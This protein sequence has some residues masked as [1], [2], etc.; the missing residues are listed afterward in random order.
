MKSDKGDNRIKALV[1]APIVIGLILIVIGIVSKINGVL[2]AGIAVLFGGSG[3]AAFITV[4][5]AM[6]WLKR[7]NSEDTDADGIESGK[8]SART[9]KKELTDSER[10]YR[11][12]IEDELT[13]ESESLLEIDYE[14]TEADIDELVD[15]EMEIETE[16]IRSDETDEDFETYVS[17]R[18]LLYEEMRQKIMKNPPLDDELFDEPEA[19]TP[20]DEPDGKAEPVSKTPI[21]E[22]T[23]TPILPTE[24]K[25]PE[26]PSVAAEHIAPETPPVASDADGESVEP[27]APSHAPTS[28]RTKRAAV[29]YKGI[30]KK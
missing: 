6:V 24:K 25:E 4:I 7:S 26:K 5:V 22:P 23:E 10:E 30:K 29:A 15:R 17:K 19:E 28:T 20:L 14:V 16:F 18:R 21:V 11:D 27:E 9:A 8:R 1:V 13:H 3:V 2:Y 12:R